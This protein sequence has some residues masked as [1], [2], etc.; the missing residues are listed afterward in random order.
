[1]KRQTK[2]CARI[3]ALTLALLL[4]IGGI[5]AL[6]EGEGGFAQTGR[7]EVSGRATRTIAPDTVDITIGVT[8]QDVD[9]QEALNQINQVM[10][11]VLESLFE[12]GLPENQIKTSYL[13]VSPRYNYN[14][15]ARPIVGYTASISMTVRLK[16]FELISAVIDTS[17][18]LGANDIGRLQF[19]HSEEGLI[20]RQALADAITVARL[21]AETM[22]D[23]A[24]VELGTLLLLQEGGFDSYDMY[25]NFRAPMPLPATSAEGDTQVMSGEMQFSASVSLTYEIK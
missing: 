6:A 16:D 5:S 23:A 7:L 2:Q 9:Q 21:K 14:Y 1:M 3:A 12:L 25:S 19:R 17:V 10:R 13:D 24:G 4:S 18:A 20:Y 15:S 8:I 22:A 11:D